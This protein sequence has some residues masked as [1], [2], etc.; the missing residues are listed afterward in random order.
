MSINATNL[1][2]LNRAPYNAHVQAVYTVDGKAGSIGPDLLMDGQE[3]SFSI[4]PNASSLEVQV[5]VTGA[6]NKNQPAPWNGAAPATLF[7][8]GTVNRAKIVPQ[9]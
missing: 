9:P 3:H 4:P 8:E 2:V 7:L 5:I 6:L 1:K